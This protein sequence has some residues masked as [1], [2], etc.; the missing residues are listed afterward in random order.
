MSKL[1]KFIGAN[2]EIDIRG[3]KIK[4]FPVTVKDMGILDKISELSKI[5]KP[6][7]EEQ[8]ESAKLCRDLIRI[9]FP[10][11][12]FTDEEI[13]KMDV[14]LFSELFSQIMEMTYD[15]KDGKGLSRIR[16]LKAKVIQEEQSKK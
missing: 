3:E 15:M 5:E 11:E 8:E 13:G 6:T 10:E 1:S 16:E 14:D 12:N 4:L 2:K 7:K 9:S